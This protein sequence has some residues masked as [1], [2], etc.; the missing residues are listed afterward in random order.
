M[1]ERKP[2][3]KRLRYEILRRDNHTCRYCGAT[4]PDTTITVDHV[5]PVALGGSNEPANLVAA[6][7]DC[8]AGKTSTSP[9]DPLVEQ[10]AADAIR[11]ARAMDAVIARRREDRDIRR[12]RQDSFAEVWDAWT[13]TQ[14][15]TFP[16]SA[17]WRTT[18]DK[19]MELGLDIA[20]F[21]ELVDVAMTTKAR[22]EPWKY[23]CG[24]CW[25]RLDDIQREIRQELS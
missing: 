6:C 16:R 4:A 12:L 17:D 21:D 7:V 10:V 19:F 22:V 9:D 13:D 15:R 18:I 25:R 1:T 14:G 5:V 8:N 23:F 24:C 3:S 2:V 20:D 11:W